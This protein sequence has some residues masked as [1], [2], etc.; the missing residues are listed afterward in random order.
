MTLIAKAVLLLWLPIAVNFFRCYP[1]RKAILITLIVGVLF[2]PQRVT[3][4]LPLIPDY[5]TQTAVVYPII[6]GL[7]IYDTK[8]LTRLEPW[9]L[10]VPILIWCISHLFAS[11]RNDLGV[12]DGINESLAVVWLYGIPYLIGRVYFNNL[13][14]VKNLAVAIVKGALIYVPLCIYEGLMSPQLHRMIYGYYGH[15]SGIGQSIRLGGYRPMVFLGHGLPIGLLMMMATLIA[16]WL[17]QSKAVREIWGFDLVYLV[18]VL[19]FTLIWVRST[20]AYFLFAYGIIILVFAKWF[21][22]NLP[23]LLLTLAIITYLY[24]AIQGNFQSRPVLEVISN[25]VPPERVQSLEFRLDE[26]VG[27]INK[28]REQFWFGWAGWSRNRVFEENFEGIFKD[29]SVTDSLWILA[30]G[31][32]GFIG[33][34]SLTFS[35]LLPSVLFPYLRYPVKTWF[36]PRVGAAA[37]FVVLLPLYMLD[38]LFNNTVNVGV[39]V[40]VMTGALT[41]LIVNTQEDLSITGAK[42]RSKTK[43]LDKISKQV[44][45]K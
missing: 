45:Q 23:L 19:V 10:D 14:N 13:D 3:F 20:G 15:S 16:V 11:I 33:I 25:F 7:L 24:I 18:P 36:Y 1:P 37:V 6:I 34:V 44:A 30:F 39:F 43:Y 28:A 41:G 27:L 29:V 26:E 9:W 8:W 21:K 32:R 4:S 17:W 42:N 5:N 22:S 38:S 12:Y 31:V 40:W 2:L 35:L